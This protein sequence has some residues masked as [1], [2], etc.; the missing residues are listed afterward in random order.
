[1][2]GPGKGIAPFRAFLEERK[3]IGAKGGNWLFFGAQKSS[4]DFFYKEELESLQREGVLTRLDTAF[5]RVQDFKIYVQH[6][7]L[8]RA[9]EL[10]N[11]LEAVAHFCVCGD[12]SL[13]D[14]D[15][16]HFLH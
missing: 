3:M 8:E 15:V 10:W 4:C 1:M 16:A 5:S 12:G 2:V 14:T 6:R 11:W 13:S 9:K 7:M